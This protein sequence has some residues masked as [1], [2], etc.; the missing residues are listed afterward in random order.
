MDILLID[1]R[2]SRSERDIWVGVLKMGCIRLF[3]LG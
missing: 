2:V 1:E 3:F